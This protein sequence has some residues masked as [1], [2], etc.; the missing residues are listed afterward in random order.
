[1]LARFLQ[2]ALFAVAVHAQSV[3]S[4]I[5]RI[6]FTFTVSG[7][8]VDNYGQDYVK[9]FTL[10]QRTPDFQLGA[11]PHGET[12]IDAK[13]YDS[14]NNLIYQSAAFT[15]DF[16]ASSAT[17]T[18]V[19]LATGYA[20]VTSD[21]NICP[22]LLSW[23]ISPAKLRPGR[24]TTVSYTTFDP[25]GV[26]GTPV[27]VELEMPTHVDGTTDGVVN[28]ANYA[29][30]DSPQD[31]TVETDQ[32]YGSGSRVINL[33]GAVEIDN[34]AGLVARDTAI[35]IKADDQQS[36][37]VDDE[38]A[39][40]IIPP[41]SDQDVDVKYGNALVSVT[42]AGGTTT[43]ASSGDTV[44]AQ[45][46][47]QEACAGDHSVQT[48]ISCV[49]VGSTADG[50]TVTDTVAAATCPQGEGTG[51]NPF[52]VVLPFVSG[53]ASGALC[54]ATFSLVVEGNTLPQTNTFTYFS[55]SYATSG[56]SV[57]APEI[58]FVFISRRSIVNGAVVSL[59]V[60]FRGE[61]AL[62]SPGWTCEGDGAGAVYTHNNGQNFDTGDFSATLKRTVIDVTVVDAAAF[63]AA[64]SKCTATVQEGSLSTSRVFNFNEAPF[65]YLSPSPT[66]A[67]T[68]SSCVA[69]SSCTTHNISETSLSKHMYP[70]Q[71]IDYHDLPPGSVIAIHTQDAHIFASNLNVDVQH[72]VDNCQEIE[73]RVTSGS[74][75][76]D[77]YIY[78][79]EIEALYYDGA[80]HNGSSLLVDANNLAQTSFRILSKPLVSTGFV[81]ELRDCATG[82][83]H[84]R[85]L[86]LEHYQ[87]DLTMPDSPCEDDVIHALVNLTGTCHV[88]FTAHHTDPCDS[89]A[90]IALPCGTV[91]QEFAGK[92]VQAAS[93]GVVTVYDDSS[94]TQSPADL[95]LTGNLD[96]KLPSNGALPDFELYTSQL[97]NSY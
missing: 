66:P 43:A 10:N 51:A 80:W 89:V 15:E 85:E 77:G 37:V 57:S 17:T 4:D 48:A 53:T 91:C 42:A 69:P 12:T 8:S 76:N 96:T 75:D 9:T 7:M 1:M 50:S 46:Q 86:V 26:D 87:Y 68:L 84:V 59:V 5:A 79:I 29:V 83:V 73:A 67:P 94:C 81:V 22:V 21:H 54:T 92:Y 40:T 3:L 78:H 30:L 16:D 56:T 90:A 45:L 25:D 52:E 62:G 20:D 34:S 55:G 36:C 11:L 49:L 38:I 27:Q 18:L 23:S 65:I 93:T 60:D 88:G 74:V 19:L 61:T 32:R 82:A 44:T 41:V 64:G 28:P 39:T 70:S 58:D 33:D 95:P 72:A 47:F 6:D 71:S 13:A 35:T 2:F 97:Y 63:V 14:S 31:V 24:N